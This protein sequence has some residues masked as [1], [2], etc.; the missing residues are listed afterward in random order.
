MRAFYSAL[1]PTNSTI[2]PTLAKVLS[3]AII[4]LDVELVNVEV[5]IAKG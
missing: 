5:D 3:A 1:L 4:D 2:V